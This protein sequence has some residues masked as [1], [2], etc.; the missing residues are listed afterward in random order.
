MKKAIKALSNKCSGCGDD[1]IF[2]PDLN[3][4]EC[5]SCKNQNKIESLSTIKKHAVENNNALLDKNTEWLSENR[6]MQCPNCGALVVLNKSQV[7]SSCHYCGSDLIASMENFHGLKPDGIIPFQFGK[8]KAIAIFNEKI[9][10]KWLVPKK[11]KNTV[12]ANEIHGYYFPTFTYNANCFT[13]YVGRLYTIENVKDKDGN[14]E[15]KRRYFNISGSKITKH[16]NVE[17]EASSKLN[18]REL[19]RIKPYDNKQTKA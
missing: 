14:T 12:N 9:K 10:N 2:N 11:F 5:P 16:E 1:M 4:V 8:Q 19:N 13:Q 15:T 7:A 17:I 18:Q 6:E 3:C